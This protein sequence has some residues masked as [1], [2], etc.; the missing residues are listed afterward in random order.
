MAEVFNRFGA[1]VYGLARLLSDPNRADRV[2]SEVFMA[3]WQSPESF[4]QTRGSLGACLLALAH[5]RTVG[6]LRRDIPRTVA[7]SIGSE[8][9]PDSLDAQLAATASLSAGAVEELLDELPDSERSAVILAYHHGYTYRQVA[10]RLHQ[11]EDSTKRAIVHG[12]TTLREKIPS[13]GPMHGRGRSRGGFTGALIEETAKEKEVGA[14][15]GA[16]R[17]AGLTH[18]EL[19]LRYFELGGMS[20]ALEV[21]A[22]LYGALQPSAHDYEV[23][24]HALNERFVELGDDRRVRYSRD[25]PYPRRDGL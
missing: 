7:D 4:D 8:K 2:T 9:G 13:G 6:L 10:A 15:D 23:M 1:S 24:A 5:S 11:S 12:L 14:L 17:D 3:L 25:H 19:W 16:R 18:G 21:E 22:L 20:S